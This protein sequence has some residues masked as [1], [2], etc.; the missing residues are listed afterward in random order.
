MRGRWLVIHLA[1]CVTCVIETWSTSSTSLAPLPFFSCGSG[2]VPIISLATHTKEKL[3]LDTSHI[4]H[5]LCHCISYIMCYMHHGKME[6]QVL[7]LWLLCPSSPV[8]LALY[9]SCHSQPTTMRNWYLIHPTSFIICA[10][11]SLTSC[12]ACVMERWSA[13]FYFSG[14]SAL[15]LLWVWLCTCHFIHNSQQGEI[16]TWY[17]SHHV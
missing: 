7:L 14:S 10:M 8:G 16:D 17:I 6:C 13:K 1:P 9:L 15:L 12:V 11:P 4:F 5:K 2:S 3:I